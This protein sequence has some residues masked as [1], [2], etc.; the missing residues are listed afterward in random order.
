MLQ[1]EKK[2]LSEKEKESYGIQTTWEAYELFYTKVIEERCDQFE[3]E[4]ESEG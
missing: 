3:Y 1:F 4:F 2:T